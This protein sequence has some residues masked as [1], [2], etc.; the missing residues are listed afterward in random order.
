MSHEPI[1]VDDGSPSPLEERLV[2]YLDGELDDAEVRQVEEMLAADSGARDV[3]AR[4]ERTWSALDKLSPASVDEVFTRTT[5]EMVS[6]KA[7]DDL[8]LQQAEV[9]RRRRRRRILGAA[10]LT[11]L[12][13][14]GFVA[15]ALWWPNPNRQVLDDLPLLENLDEY[16]HVFSKEDDGIR[17]LHLLKQNRLFVKDA[18]DD[19]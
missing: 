17:F 16:Q 10:Y 5:L 18:A 8:A 4:L 15:V 3:L 19:S 13:V 2:A 11:A 12:A 7:A 14:A 1:E 9:P 6:I